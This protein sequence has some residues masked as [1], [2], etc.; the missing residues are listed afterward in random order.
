MEEP[1]MPA[2]KGCI[3]WKEPEQGFYAALCSQTITVLLV[4]GA[5]QS[6]DKLYQKL[7][8]LHLEM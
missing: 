6:S 2:T 7:L 3:S 5:A 1:L 4:N 8:F